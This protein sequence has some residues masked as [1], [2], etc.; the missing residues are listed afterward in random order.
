MT[1]DERDLAAAAALGVLP[2]DELAQVESAAARSSELG[3]ELDDY[4]AVVSF[5]EASLV[6]EEP[7]PGLFEEVLARVEAE[8]AAP[9]ARA[10]AE[11]APR[12]RRS[13]PARARRLWPAFA[14]GAVLATAATV[15]VIALTGGGLG[16]PDARAAIR[17]SDEFPGVHGEARLYRSHGDRG[18]VVVDLSDVPDPRPDEHY[19]VW[20]LRKAGAGAMEAVGSF[21]AG[22]PRVDLELPLPGPGGYE[23]VDVSVEP[24]GGPAAHSGRSL[25]GG[26]FARVT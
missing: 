12:E 11:R 4:R 25:A 8:S 9:R 5:L 24:N 20:V 15:L 14:A 3:A 26:R 1:D 17:G 10:A 19:E 6:R 23:A 7:P 21:A 2:R 18:V 16:S 13:L 22:G